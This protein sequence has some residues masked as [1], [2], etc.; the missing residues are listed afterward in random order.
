MHQRRPWHYVVATE[1]MLAAVGVK[2]ATAVQYDATRGV[3]ELLDDDAGC[4]EWV[5]RTKEPNFA[6]TDR[7]EAK[8]GIT[9]IYMD[10]W[11]IDDFDADFVKINYRGQRL[12]FTR[13]MQ[14]AFE[15]LMMP[16]L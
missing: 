4:T 13:P 12:L 1:A 16:F 3:L 7:L 14:R 9:A 11:M 5:V 2:S 6:W 8:F 10:D 15:R